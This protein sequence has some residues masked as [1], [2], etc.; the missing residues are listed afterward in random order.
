MPKKIYK[1]DFKKNVCPV[2]GS[3]QIQHSNKEFYAGGHEILADWNCLKC[4]S[5]GSLTYKLSFSTYNNAYSGENDDE[6]EI[7]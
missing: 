5:Y 4:G 3:K 1:K 6:I 7:I 2:C